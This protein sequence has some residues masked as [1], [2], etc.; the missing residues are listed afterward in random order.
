MKIKVHATQAVRFVLGQRITPEAPANFDT[1][2]LHAS[3]MAD[4]RTTQAIKITTAAGGKLV[5]D[6]DGQLVEV[7]EKAAEKTP[8]TK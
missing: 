4:L 3:E 6:E 8:A 5:F 1:E 2:K 7:K